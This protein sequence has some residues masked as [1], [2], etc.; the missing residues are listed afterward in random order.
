MP[1][2]RDR[3]GP[4]ILPIHDGRIELRPAFA[5]E[6]RAV[7]G[8][9]ERVVFERAHG[10]R[11]RIEAGAATFEKGKGRIEHRREAHAIARALVRTKE[12]RGNRARTAVYGN[13]IHG[14]AHGFLKMATSRR[15]LESRAA[16]NMPGLLKS[17]TR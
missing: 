12:V 14:I 3:A 17:I 8:V 16:R 15:P 9:E 7:P 13:G 5:R 1:N 2:R 4:L 11:H 10:A 6:G